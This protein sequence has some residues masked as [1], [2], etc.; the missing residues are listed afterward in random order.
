[1]FLRAKIQ[2]KEK[3][4][5]RGG[6]KLKEKREKLKREREKGF[7]LLSLPKNSLNPKR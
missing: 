1:L 2:E 5:K 3:R 4:E 7:F 6:E